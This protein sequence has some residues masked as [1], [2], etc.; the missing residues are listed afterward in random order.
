MAPKGAVWNRTVGLS[1]CHS[2]S[3]SVGPE[4]QF[5][6]V[7]KKKSVVGVGLEK[8]EGPCSPPLTAA[9]S[10]ARLN[11]CL[12]PVALWLMQVPVLYLW[13]YGIDFNFKS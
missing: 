8:K 11:Y 7:G 4:V 3:A 9:T 10:I 1:R 6:K 12:R 13:F 2:S 5:L